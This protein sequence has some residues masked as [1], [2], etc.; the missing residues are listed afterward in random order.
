MAYEP[1]LSKIHCTNNE[2]QAANDDKQK[3][4]EAFGEGKGD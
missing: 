1:G 3:M 4:T 2:M